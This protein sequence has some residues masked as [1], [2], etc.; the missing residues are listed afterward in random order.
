MR[1]SDLFNQR[2]YS[3]EKE[4]ENFTE[5][6]T[7][8]RESRYLKISLSYLFGK[9]EAREKNNKENNPDGGAPE[10]GNDSQEF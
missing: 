7:Y 1:L 9:L 3:R 4:Y 5:T 10:E 8:R 6:S 2:Q